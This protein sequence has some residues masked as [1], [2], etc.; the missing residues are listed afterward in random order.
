[1]FSFNT[2]KA[3]NVA[4]ALAMAV[5]MTACTDEEVATTLGAAAIVAGAVIIAENTECVGGYRTVC[6][7]SYGYYGRRRTQCREV[8][9][10]CLYTRIGSL[11]QFADA[12]VTASAVTDVK[13][14]TTFGGNFEGSAKFISALEQARDQ[15]SLKG[16]KE[17][18]LSKGSIMKLAQGQMPEEKQINAVAKNLDQD[19]ES[20]RAMLETLLVKSQ[21]LQKK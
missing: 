21:E 5:N 12:N 16:L 4:L 10:S 11:S 2:K 3:L 15:K 7:D 6:H 1:M 19:L 9:D 17:I 18:G 8:Y 20:T 13:W 14:A